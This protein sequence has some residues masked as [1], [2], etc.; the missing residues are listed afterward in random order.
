MAKDARKRKKGTLIKI[1]TLWTKTQVAVL[2]YFKSYKNNPAGYREIA[3]AYGRANYPD[4]KRACDQLFRKGYLDKTEDDLF[5]VR[6]SSLEL[7]K[8]GK[9]E[10]S[11]PYFNESLRRLKERKSNH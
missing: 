11:L 2:V 3:R 1:H 9:E 10:I 8:T 7:A 5:Y 4:Y 6:D